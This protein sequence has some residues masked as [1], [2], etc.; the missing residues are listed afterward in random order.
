[1]EVFYAE[2]CFVR[3]ISNQPG[4]RSRTFKSFPFKS[5]AVCTSWFDHSLF[6]FITGVF[7]L[8]SPE[9]IT[10]CSRF[11][12]FSWLWLKGRGPT[13]LS[14]DRCKLDIRTHQED[15]SSI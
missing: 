12:A 13:V 6:Q 1:M 15:F 14:T 3:Q 8:S 9:F 7:P 5:T 11:G 2:L 4:V 10:L